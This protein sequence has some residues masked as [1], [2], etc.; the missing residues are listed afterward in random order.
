MSYWKDINPLHKKYDGYTWDIK[1]VTKA[2][3]VSAFTVA[4]K[5]SLENGVKLFEFDYK[6]I[7][8]EKEYD[9]LKLRYDS[10]EILEELYKSMSFAY[11]TLYTEC[12]RW[13]VENTKVSG[14][15]NLEEQLKKYQTNIVDDF[16]CPIVK[17]LDANLMSNLNF[18]SNLKRI[19]LFSEDRKINSIDILLYGSETPII[20]QPPTS[21]GKNLINSVINIVYR[22]FG[23]FLEI[24]S[25]HGK[26]RQETISE[27]LG[28]SFCQTMPI[29]FAIDHFKVFVNCK[30]KNGEP[31]L[32]QKQFDNFINRAFHNKTD[33][34]KERFNCGPREKLFIL[35]RFYEF[36]QKGAADYEGTGQCRDKYIKLISDNFQN[37]SFTGIKNNFGNKVERNW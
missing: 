4:G 24:E 1:D 7:L 22:R 33:I 3:K 17:Y 14:A 18:Y 10:P 21:L 36:Y 34:P 25:R 13:Y 27:N 16:C 19:F 9:N 30:S 29:G 20:P 35:K 28:N 12:M 31:F 6:P 32:S 23:D 5:N 2:Q 11:F 8:E 37:W 15:F 26:S